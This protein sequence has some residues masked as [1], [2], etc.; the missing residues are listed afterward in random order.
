MYG[1]VTL[2]EVLDARE[3][4]VKIQ[5]EIIEKYKSTLISLTLNIPG[6]LKVYPLSI[7][8]YNEAI[9]LITKHL[10]RHHINIIYQTDKKEKT[11]YEGF[12]VVEGNPLRIKKLMVDIENSC[13]LGRI[14]DIDVLDNSGN[15]V[16]RSELNIA[17]RSCLICNDNGHACS[18]SRRHEAEELQRKVIEIMEDYFYNQ[19]AKKCAEYA[20]RALL[21]EVCITPKPGL[22]DRNNNGSHKDMD[23][24][25][26]IDSASVL[27]TYFGDL[28][29]SGI[30]YHDEKPEILFEKI[31]YLGMLAEDDMFFITNN[32][33]THKGIIFSLGIICASLGYLYKNEKDI[34][35]DNI[36][37][38]SKLMTSEIDDDFKEITKENAKTYGEKLYT[39]YG[40]T[41]IRGEA[42]G[43]F[44]SVKIH[45]L[46]ILKKLIKKG[47][48]LNE[49][50]ALTLLN[51]IANVKDTNIIARS[52]I[53]LL[54]GIQFRIQNLIDKKGIENI[55]NDE[56]IDLDN[57]FIKMNI[58]PGGC[59]DLL[60]ITLMLY[61]SES[62]T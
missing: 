35:T 16:S 44:P 61:F 18:R 20:C 19:F 2:S 40:I 6:G 58:S 17:E 37:K 49:A 41:G 14:F 22:V 43:G 11:G 4:R 50:G 38:I 12:F 45:G 10:K 48:S 52:S 27:T 26:F 55:S 46:P 5:R 54:E 24:F 30:K 31:R 21:Y 51:L 59:A 47:Y 60:A 23:M 8:T 39:S 25:T 7:K 15:K 9:S 36:L 42:A 33:N 32:V 57:Q 34:N 53:E 56:I 1:E 29:L 13:G 28:I 3:N 62:L